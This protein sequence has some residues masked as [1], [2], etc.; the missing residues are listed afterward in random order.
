MADYGHT[1]NYMTLSIKEHV[2]IQRR[3]LLT[4]CGAVWYGTRPR[5]D[6]PTKKWLVGGM[7]LGLS[8]PKSSADER[9]NTARVLLAAMTTFL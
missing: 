1:F 4:G 8:F 6:T 3:A 5:I 7:L 9:G 2:A